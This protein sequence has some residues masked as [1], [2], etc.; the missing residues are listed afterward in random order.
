MYSVMHHLGCLDAVG[1]VSQMFTQACGIHSVEVP[2]YFM[3][4]GTLMSLLLYFLALPFSY[5]VKYSGYLYSQH[6]E[7]YTEP[8]HDSVHD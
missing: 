7:H 6:N 2:C 8:L 1:P 3:F 4:Q 5:D